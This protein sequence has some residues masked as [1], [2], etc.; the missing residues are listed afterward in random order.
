[1][2]SCPLL[3]G[4]IAT[5]A[6]KRY[7]PL[8]DVLLIRIFSFQT[9]F[10]YVRPSEWSGKSIRPS[11]ISWTGP[12]F[13]LQN[14]DVRCLNVTPMPMGSLAKFLPILMLI[15][16]SCSEV[17]RLDSDDVSTI[18]ARIEILEEEVRVFS[19][20]RDTEFELFNVNGFKSQS[21][22]L[23]IPGASSQDYK[24]VVK[25][26]TSNI[27]KWTEGMVKFDPG[28]Y[29]DEWTKEIV[30]KRSGNWKTS[31]EPVYFLRQGENVRLVLF[32]DN[33]IIFKRVI[34]N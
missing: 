9:A 31:C 23:A 25:V 33:G 21:Q 5:T 22:L 17:T 28:P 1:V 16:I 32:Q 27:K 13:T 8:W 10:G 19:E 18:E 4:R 14:P 12:S 6:N 7:V 3:K 15:L 24:F 30:N 34:T 11:T 2:D 20:I 29:D 26:D